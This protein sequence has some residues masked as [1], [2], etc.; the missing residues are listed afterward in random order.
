MAITGPLTGPLTSGIVGSI[1]GIIQRYFTEF[2]SVSSSYI[3]LD[4]AWQAAG[5]FEIEFDYLTSSAA[6]LQMFIGDTLSPNNYLAITD[7]GRL[8]PKING[9]NAD[10][11]EGLLPLDGKLNRIRLIRDASDFCTLYLNGV[12][13]YTFTLGGLFVITAIGRNSAGFYF[14][15]IEANVKLNDIAGGDNRLYRIDEDGTNNVVVDAIGGSNATRVN[16]TADNADLYTK[17][18]GTWEGLNTSLISSSGVLGDDSDPETAVVAGA[19]S[20]NTYAISANVLTYVGTQDCG[21]ASTTGV[22]GIAPFRGSNLSP[23]DV[24]GGEYT[25]TSTGNIQLFGRL[26]AQ[27]E[28]NGISVQRILEIA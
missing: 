6:S 22:P 23:G 13:V 3:A 12:S 18:D 8:R 20:G 10:S 7:T 1:T 11:S 9:I 27:V 21:F 25:A 24:V 5:E 26:L 19:I 15:G 14:S 4:T 2:F 17:I 28:F 16:M